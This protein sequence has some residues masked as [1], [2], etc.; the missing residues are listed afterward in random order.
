MKVVCD[1]CGQEVFVS[2]G[3]FIQHTSS[4]YYPD[5]CL[6]SGADVVKCSDFSC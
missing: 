1:L 2:N 6:R 3:Y 4:K 5:Y